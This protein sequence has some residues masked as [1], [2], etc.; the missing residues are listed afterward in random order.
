M[1]SQLRFPHSLGWFWTIGET[2]LFFMATTDYPEAQIVGKL[3]A[4]VALSG[5]AILNVG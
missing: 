1:I 5:R 4:L 2:V 3:Y